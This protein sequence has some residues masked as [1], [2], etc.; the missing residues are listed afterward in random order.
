[1]AEPKI[2]V[3]NNS[4]V[5]EVLGEEKVSGVKLD[6]GKTIDLEGLF[7]EIGRIPQSEIAK[8]LG[9]EL[10]EKGEVKTNRYSETNIPGFYAAG[11]V[12]ETNFKQA[13][14]S[15]AEGSHAAARAFEFIG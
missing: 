11:D 3:I 7:I 2:E 8:Q 5:I 1:E 14:V 15:A 6:T 13:I 10:N 9:A 12:T 4:N